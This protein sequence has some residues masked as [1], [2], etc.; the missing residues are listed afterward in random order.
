MAVGTA[1]CNNGDYNG[2]GFDDVVVGQGFYDGAATDMGR[3]NLWY[4]PV[5]TSDSLGSA[6]YTIDGDSSRSSDQFG[7]T[8]RFAGDV[9]GDGSDDLLSAAWR[10]HTDDRGTAYLFLGGN[11]S[12]SV[13]GADASF[14]TTGAT[15]Y[16]GYSFDG[17]ESNGDTR[18][19]LLISAYGYSSGVGLVAFY[20]G[21]TVSGAEDL[22]TTATALITST[23]AG[24]NLGYSVAMGDLDSDGMADFILGAPSA[25]S[26]TATGAVYVFLGGG[27]LTGSV[28]ATAADYTLSG[29]TAADRLGISVA[30]LGDTD[31][32]GSGD[33]AVAA[34]KSDLAAADAGAVYVINATPTSSMT[35]AAAATTIITGEVAT[36]FFGRS[37]A[38][39]GDENLDGT[40]ELMVGATAY[41]VGALSGAGAVYFFY[42]PYASGTVAASTYDARFTGANT[43]DAVG[44]ALSGGGDVNG[45]GRGDWM[46]AAT[47]WDGSGF[48]NSGGSWL[49]YGAGQ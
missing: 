23:T 35:A 17:A 42:G 30:Y 43:S 12:S 6:D 19:D 1:V 7:S 13:S 32:D 41:D 14:T 21:T 38:G 3:T 24:G 27:S 37:V 46:S 2:D 20:D 45:D 49:Y 18:S 36:D 28:A 48:L 25:S 5:G 39:V 8:T 10:S 15:S 31:L 40:A 44:A 26:T 11:A 22:A 9:N 4:G 34:D 16:V 47:S 29:A 33:F